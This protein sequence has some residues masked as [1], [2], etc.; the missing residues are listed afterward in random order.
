MALLV[1][2]AMACGSSNSNGNDAG[3]DGGG[4]NPAPPTLGAQVDRQARSVVNTV[5]IHGFDA[6]MAARGAAK[7]AYNAAAPAT[8][9]SFKGEIAKNL[10]ILDGLDTVCGNQLLAGTT[11]APGRYDA[12][13]G[14]LADDQLYVNTATGTC[15]QYFAVELG[16]S[17][18]CG[19]RA[20]TY[21]TIDVTL[22]A[23]AIGM[24]SGVTDGIAA[25]DK[26]Q[27]NT[28]FPF[29]AD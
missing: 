11:A 3:N 26:T 2:P 8:W 29:L 9:A 23:A 7:D 6:D 16:M 28:T 19:G 4:N 25:D 21:D 1:L 17:T 18:N 5:L 10:A 13:A 14:V 15:T 22:S 20:P 12:L 27:S 24:P